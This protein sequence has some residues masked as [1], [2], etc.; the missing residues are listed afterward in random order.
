MCACEEEEGAGEGEGHTY[1]GCQL[2]RPPH[3][4]HCMCSAPHPGEATIAM[5]WCM[6]VG[7]PYP[8][9]SWHFALAPPPPVA[10]CVPLPAGV[11]ISPE[12]LRSLFREYVQGTDDEMRKP[13]SKGGTGLGLS[14]CSKQVGPCF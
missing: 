8:C 5:C 14:I 10:A 3:V 11:G 4:T 1:D 2:G 9:Q 12:G 7:M 13:R 6:C